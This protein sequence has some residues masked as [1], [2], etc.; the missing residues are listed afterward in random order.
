MWA[1]EDPPICG[2]ITK[3][4]TSV[5]LLLS[6][7]V[8]CSLS[9]SFLYPSF[10]PSSISCLPSYFISA[11][12]LLPTPLCPPLW[13]AFSPAQASTL[14]LLPSPSVLTVGLR[15]VHWILISHKHCASHSSTYSSEQTWKTSLPQYWKA[16]NLPANFCTFF[17]F[18]P[19]STSLP[20]LPYLPLLLSTFCLF[21]YLL[22]LCLLTCC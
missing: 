19:V 9:P 12:S 21:L 20:G 10:L 13:F 2:N 5:F 22:L 8:I 3:P 6:L 17:L 14:H 11:P 1:C 7:F 16:Y 18:R 15:Q 4:L